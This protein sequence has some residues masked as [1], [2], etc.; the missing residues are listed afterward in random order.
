MKKMML[1]VMM[2]AVAFASCTNDEEVNLHDSRKAMDV[3]V[4]VNAFSRAMVTGTTLAEG[5]QIGISVVQNADDDAYDGMTE[6][7]LN[8][9]YKAPAVDGDWGPSDESKQILLSGT[10][11]KAVAYYPYDETITPFDYKAIPV[12]IADQTDWMW[13]AG[14]KTVTDASS[15]VEFK[16]KHAQTAVNVNVVRD[17]SYTGAGAITA[18]TV[19]SEGLAQTGTLNAETGVFADVDGANEAV[20][21]MAAAFT[22][23]GT[24]LTSQENPYMFI[25]ASAE[26]KNFVV[27]ATV[28]GKNYNV[29]VTMSEAFTAGT[30]YKINVKISNVGLIVDSVVILNDWQNEPLDEGTLKPAA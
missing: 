28:D 7:Y 5:E 23:D 2:L 17:A 18:L 12:D 14:S 10:E 9:A 21:I 29:T 4:T 30:V 13:A 24:T 3:D 25:P 22:L 26:V 20:S 8:V 11:G 1:P 6:G 27:A 16:L 19:Q 15:N